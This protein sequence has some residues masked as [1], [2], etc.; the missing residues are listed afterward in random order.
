MRRPDLKL[1]HSFILIEIGENSH[2]DS[3]EN[4]YVHAFIGLINAIIKFRFIIKTS[5]GM[6]L[7]S[8]IH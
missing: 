6:F 4:V 7:E 2:D 8:F 1:F 5:F 3:L